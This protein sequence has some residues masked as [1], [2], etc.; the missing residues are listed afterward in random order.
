MG[1]RRGG[2]NCTYEQV[3]NEW[4]NDIIVKF[5]WIHEIKKYYLTTTMSKYLPHIC[6]I[7]S[8]NKISLQTALEQCTKA[9]VMT[10]TKELSHQAYKNI[11]VS[12]IV[13]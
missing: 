4:V 6:T 7:N 3:L 9:L 1:E 10:P 5:F 11:L 13:G 8:S 2:G 12:V